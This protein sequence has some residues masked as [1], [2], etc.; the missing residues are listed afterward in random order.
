MHVNV[1]ATR[2][3]LGTGLYTHV[4]CAHTCVIYPHEYLYAQT[5]NHMP[6]HV[7]MCP[8]TCTQ[9][10]NA[11]TLMSTFLHL[12]VHTRL[13]RHTHSCGQCSEGSSA[14]PKTTAAGLPLPQ[15]PLRLS[16]DVS[17]MGA[18]LG[19]RCA[20]VGA[21]GAAGL[22]GHSPG[23]GYPGLFLH[24]HLWPQ[25]TGQLCVQKGVPM[26]G[27]RPRVALGSIPKEIMSRRP[28]APSGVQEAPCHWE[29]GRWQGSGT[30]QGVGSEGPVG[31]PS[32][33]PY[34]P[35]AHAAHR[36]VAYQRIVFFISII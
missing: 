32:P 16:W 6:T 13:C 3:H 8:R 17:P 10:H 34:L 15:R 29:R 11:H 25:D 33:P 24:G 19:A 28:E 1:S 14:A 35:L 23:K 20:G 12:C 7:L 31:V 30:G 18:L 22:G 2:L 4:A 36:S 26:G 9:V 27:A 5:S 21:D